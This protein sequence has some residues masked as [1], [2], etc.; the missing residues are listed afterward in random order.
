MYASLRPHLKTVAILFLVAAFLAGGTSL[1][2]DANPPITDKKFQ[3]V[4]EEVKKYF[5]L[6]EDIW[7]GRIAFKQQVES[8]PKTGTTCSATWPRCG[9]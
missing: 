5:N 9:G 2:A 4:V 3:E 7:R 8:T 1:Q 6:E